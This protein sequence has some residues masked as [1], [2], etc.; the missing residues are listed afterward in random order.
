MYYLISNSSLINVSD[1][2]QNKLNQIEEN[3]KQSTIEIIP[4]LD[5][6][7]NIRFRKKITF[8]LFTCRR[9]EGCDRPRGFRS[10]Q[11]GDGG[12][13]DRRGER[14]RTTSPER[15]VTLL[16]TGRVGPVSGLINT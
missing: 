1:K 7:W 9:A 14:G 2:N 10:L 3:L 16:T 11:R 4:E 8:S 13:R 6:N 12:E 5:P 15:M